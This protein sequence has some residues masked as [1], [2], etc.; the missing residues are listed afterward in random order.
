MCGLF[1]SVGFPPDKSCLD[2]VAHRGPDGAE[3]MT[4]DS[5]AGPVALGHR[6]LSIIDLDARARQPMPSADRRYWLV[7]NGEIYNYLELKAELAADGVR[8]RTTS[9]A[10]VLV[11][12]YARAGVAFL[13]RLVGMFAFL[14]WDDLD[15]TLFLAR[16]HMG[17]KPLVFHESPRGVA[18]ASEIKQLLRL[19]QFPRRIRRDR[20]RDFLETGVTDH[21][22]ETMFEGARNVLAGDCARLDFRG[23][24]VDPVAFRPYWRP[25]L[26]DGVAVSAEEAAARFKSL[27]FDSIRLQLRADVRVGSCLSG[28]LD[29]SSIVCAQTLL[30]PESAEPLNVVSAVFPGSAVDESRFMD[31]VVAATGAH[32]HRVT[33][34]PAAIFD[35]LD[36]TLA[37]QDEPYGSTSIHAQHHVFRTARAAGV[38]VMLDGQGADEL[39]AGY[40]GCFS[41]YYRE[42]ILRGRAATLLRAL[43]ERKAWHGLSRRAQLDFA[44]RRVPGLA[45]LA[46]LPR[47]VGDRPFLKGPAEDGGVIG[48]AARAHGLPVPHDVGAYCVLVTRATSLPMLLRFED[49]NSMAHSIE[50][51]VPFLDHRLVEF[52]LK[53]GGQHKLV[54]GDTKRVLRDA[55]AGVL[56]EMI[57]QRRDKIG[58]ATPEEAWFKGPLR[59]AVAARV[60]ATLAAFPDAF[61]A[62]AARAAVAARLD[63]ARPFDFLPWRILN[64]GAWAE[65]FGM[66]S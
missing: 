24:R 32:S 26:P 49:R 27:F 16:D 51:R 63:G 41:Y 20:A 59:R 5:P 48:A 64:F 56:P 42:L 43:N 45:A 36:A 10:E 33:F 40:H 62:D 23:G 22:A 44:L 50:A 4:F 7:F 14:I 28:G 35:D 46:G 2:A 19:P 66:A 30:R 54:G 9:D 47:A 58:F 21:R 61:D 52:C 11:E 37:A 25:P 55:M 60:D 31:G 65:R 8:F 34:D 6:R 12:G 1:V 57:R 13:S 39:L 3:W 38:K 17:V 29:S 53:L 18:F 15:K